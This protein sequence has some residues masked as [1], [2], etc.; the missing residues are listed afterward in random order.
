LAGLL[1]GASSMAL[2]EWVSV[3]SSRELAE[4]ELR[5][6]ADELE[7]APEEEREELQLIY[8]AKGIPPEEAKQL[9]SRLL[10]D[11]DTALGVLAREELGLDP[12]DLGGSP[13]VAAIT[14]FVLFAFGALFPVLPFMFASGNLA[15]AISIVLS[16]FTL[17][18]VGAA[19][20]LFT[21]RSVWI[22]GGRQV[23]LGLGAAGLT[24][25]LG[26]VLGVALG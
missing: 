2:G 5:V 15:V 4:R 16:G 18:A 26:R 10:S 7:L 21:G 19:I 12:D 8:E 13:R 3:K 23:V 9:S 22:T 25:G 11:K 24:Y 20:T 1:A 17:F 6:E 14:S